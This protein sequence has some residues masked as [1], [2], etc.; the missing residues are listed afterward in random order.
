MGSVTLDLM[1]ERRADLSCFVRIPAA[2]LEALGSPAGGAVGV[3]LDGH[4]IGQ[5]TLV[6][7]DAGTFSLPLNAAHLRLAGGR[8]A[9]DRVPVA[10]TVPDPPPPPDPPPA[11][12]KRSRKK[13]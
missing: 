10:L 11:P 9:G 7:Y 12:A 13:A 5:R 3:V 4:P 6:R 8:S 1:I 2:T